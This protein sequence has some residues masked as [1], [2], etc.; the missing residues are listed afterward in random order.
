MCHDFKNILIMLC[1]FEL[2]FQTNFCSGYEFVGHGEKNEIFLEVAMDSFSHALK[3]AHNAKVLRI[4]LT[5][6]ATA[7]LTLDILLVSAFDFVMI[8]FKTIEGT[9][10]IH[11]IS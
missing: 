2:L 3:S 9:S 1:T 11:F 4:K 7:C 5:Q 8:S 10:S 6:K